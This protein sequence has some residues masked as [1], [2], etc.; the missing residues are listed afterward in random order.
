MQEEHYPLQAVLYSVALHRHLR[1]TLPGYRPEEHLAGV[2]YYY[3]RVVGDPS[4]EGTDGFAAWPISPAAVVAASD[5]ME[6]IVA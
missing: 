1:A 3:L 5:A 2:G 4:R 6:G